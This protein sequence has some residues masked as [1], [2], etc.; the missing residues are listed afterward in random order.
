MAG[1][2]KKRGLLHWLRAKLSKAGRDRQHLGQRPGGTGV[3]QAFPGQGSPGVAGAKAVGCHFW[4]LQQ[5]KG[6]EVLCCVYLAG[7]IVRLSMWVSYQRP[8]PSYVVEL[9]VL[10]AVVCCGTRARLV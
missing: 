3:L 8:P 1:R 10:R 2:S 9:V 5:R 6:S 4:H 7:R